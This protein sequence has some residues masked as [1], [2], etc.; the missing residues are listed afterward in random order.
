MGNKATPRT[1]KEGFFRYITVPEEAKRWAQP[2][3][4]LFS[5]FIC[6]LLAWHGVRFVYFEWQDGNTL[7]SSVPAWVCELIIPLGF[8]I[9]ALRFLISGLLHLKPRGKA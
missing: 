3:T 8:C 9:M 2:I 5:S 4:D 1:G 6:G 7:F